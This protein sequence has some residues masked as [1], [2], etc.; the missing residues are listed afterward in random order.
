MQPRPGIDPRADL[1]HEKAKQDAA[2]AGAGLAR[3]LL[4][5]LLVLPLR[6]LVGSYF[7][8]WFI[9]PIWP[10]ARP[11]SVVECIG[12]LLVIAMFTASTKYN[13]KDE[14]SENDKWLAFFV[15][16]PGLLVIWLIGWLFL[17]LA[18]L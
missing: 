11:L 5:F 7:W 14:R 3:F 9:L 6:A 4:G 18:Y 13:G 2:K 17:R 8:Q 12:V 10:N 16:V 15:H 1:A